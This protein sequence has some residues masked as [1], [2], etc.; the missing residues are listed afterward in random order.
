MVARILKIVFQKERN[1]IYKPVKVMHQH[2]LHE[3]VPSVKAPVPPGDV[4][5]IA[6]HLLPHPEA[7]PS[8]LDF[9]SCPLIDLEQQLGDVILRN[10]ML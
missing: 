7:A 1:P 10:T 4:K 3:K 8:G 2:L 6:E 5:A 9:Y